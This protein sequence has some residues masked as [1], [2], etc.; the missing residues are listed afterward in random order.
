[1]VKYNGK[2]KA[3]DWIG[4]KVEITKQFKLP[5]LT[6]YETPTVVKQGLVYR[7][8]GVSSSGG[9][10]LEL[11]KCENLLSDLRF[12]S[13]VSYDYVKELVE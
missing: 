8:V 1:M 12:L 11:E 9:L 7:V 6:G 3:R 4:C 5:T 10:N 13:V 2:K